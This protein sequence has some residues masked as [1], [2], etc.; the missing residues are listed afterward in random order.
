MSRALAWIR[1]SK[2]SDDDIGLEMQRSDVPALAEDLAEEVD[3]LDLGVHTGFS[4]LSRDDEDMLDD[5]EDVQAAVDELRAG[6]YDFL[7]A[8]DDRRICRD[9]YLS[10]IEY[11]CVQGDCEIVFVSDDVAD[12]DLAYDIHRRV[13]RET[14]EEEIR[15]SKAAIRERQE[16]GMWQGAPPVGLEFDENGEYLVPNDDFDDVMAV[17]ERVDEETYGEIASDLG[18]GK[19]TVSRIVDRGREFY[20]ARAERESP[21]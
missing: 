4:T 7:V 3:I 21:A 13:E 10:I 15:K 12:D 11:A 16:R 9:D 5:H 20:E 14:K 2:G 17:F 19:G 1:K 6:K 8:V 18:V